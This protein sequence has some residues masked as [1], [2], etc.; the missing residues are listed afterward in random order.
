MK[1]ELCPFSK[2]AAEKTRS[3]FAL[4]T[5]H[6]YWT[7][8][9]QSQKSEEKIQCLAMFCLYTLP[10]ARPAQ[11]KIQMLTTSSWSVTI[12]LKSLGLY[13][14]PANNK[15]LLNAYIFY[16]YFFYI[17]MYLYIFYI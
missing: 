9:V 1:F 11:A 4:D 14:F 10:L 3:Y 8:T 16:I 12:L 7:V 13:L 17:Y 2:E 6:Q 5:V 15:V